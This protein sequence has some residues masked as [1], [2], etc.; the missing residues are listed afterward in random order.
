MI[1]S[2]ERFGYLSL[3]SHPVKPPKIHCG[4]SGHLPLKSGGLFLRRVQNQIL[5]VIPVGTRTRS[6]PLWIDLLL[7]YTF[8]APLL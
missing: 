5:P 3:V 7:L 6:A 4:K 2:L 8:L 1:R